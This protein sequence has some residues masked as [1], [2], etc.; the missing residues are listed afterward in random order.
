MKEKLSA[1]QNEMEGKTSKDCET[2]NKTVVN[3][4]N[5]VLSQTT[6][7]F[8]NVLQQ[9]AGVFFLYFYFS[10]RALKLKISLKIVF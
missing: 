6:L 3:Y 10:N 9:R 8:R 7:E 2:H 5:V 4:L 1:L